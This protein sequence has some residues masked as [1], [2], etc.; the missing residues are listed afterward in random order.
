MNMKLS[1]VNYVILGVVLF[2]VFSWINMEVGSEGGLALLAT[3]MILCTFAI[4]EAI[5]RK[6]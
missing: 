4:V 2:Y 6:K 1:F 3:V 5:N